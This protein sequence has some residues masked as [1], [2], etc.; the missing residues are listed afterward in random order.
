[1]SSTTKKGSS[2]PSG[3][4]NHKTNRKIVHQTDLDYNDHA[5]PGSDSEIRSRVQNTI[6]NAWPMFLV[7]EGTDPDR[8][9]SKLS[10]LP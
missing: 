9:L 8:P 7:V 1:M 6:L 5:D 10:P 4:A 3:T 2:D